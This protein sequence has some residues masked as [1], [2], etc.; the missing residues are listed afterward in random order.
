MMKNYNTKIAAK[1]Q[2]RAQVHHGLSRHK[3]PALAVNKIASVGTERN[4]VSALKVFGKWLL[5]KTGRHLKNASL[6][7]ATQ[8]LKERSKTVKQKTLD[9][10]RQALNMNFNFGQKLVF[11][12]SQVATIKEDR[13]YSKSALA[14]LIARADPPLRLAI[15]VAVYAGL[16]PVELI[17]IA[18]PDVLT[19]SAR[20]WSQQ[21][22]LGR[23]YDEPFCVVGKGG[24]IRQVRLEASLA[25][26]LKELARPFP[27]TVTDR[28]IH[29]KS[30]FLLPG[31]L[32]FSQEFSLLSMQV[33]GFSHGAHGLRHSF[34]QQRLIALICLGQD[35]ISAI[36]VLAQEMGHFS[37]KNTMTYLQMRF[38]CPAPRATTPDN[39]QALPTRSQVKYLAPK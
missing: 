35:P 16:R 30:Y 27:I 7:N 20:D 37:T 4:H 18:L 36:E 34:A 29:R 1:L 9:L 39:T 11:L 25:L 8:Y 13:A 26:R 24:L 31:G 38:S 6:E 28:E 15:E 32:E 33:L 10:D 22:F 17:S 2:V 21:R 23:I 5:L 3:D 14:L 19:E 12:Q